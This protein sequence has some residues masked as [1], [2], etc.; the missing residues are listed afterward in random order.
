MRTLLLQGEH[1][2]EEDLKA[3]DKKI[4]DVVNESAEF[5]KNSPEPALD[6]L[7]TDIYATEIP[8]EA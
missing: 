1:A 4:K 6:E 2:T 3:I 5:A 7:W 8:Q